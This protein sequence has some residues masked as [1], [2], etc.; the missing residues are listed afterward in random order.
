MGV[1]SGDQHLVLVVIDDQI[2][3]AELAGGRAALAADAQPGVADGHAHPGQQLRRAEGLG[4]VVVGA[5]VQGLHLVLLV[6]AGRNHQDRQ[7]RPLADRADDVHAVDVRQ[8]QIQHHQIRAVGTDHGE[9]LAA[10]VGHDHVVA[11]AGQDGADKTGD[12]LFVLDDE[13]FVTNRHVLS[14]LRVD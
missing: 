8:A 14:L 4:D 2:P 9:G 7:L 3:G 11:V 13:D 5:P 10:A 1:L 6:A 12:A